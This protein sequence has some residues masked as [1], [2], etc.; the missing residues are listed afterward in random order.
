MVV[1]VK[2]TELE[3]S[4][5]GWERRDL[6][7]IWPINLDFEPTQCHRLGNQKSVASSFQAIYEHM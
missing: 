6:K 3:E 1:N 4:N 7:R 2:H 5:L